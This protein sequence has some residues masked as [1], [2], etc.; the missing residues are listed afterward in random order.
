VFDF[1]VAIAL[2]LLNG[3]F[4]LSE[5]AIVS[6]RKAR[7]KILADQGRTGAKAALALADD[8]GRFLSTIQIGITLIGIVA[9]AYSGAAFGQRLADIFLDYGLPVSWAEFLGYGV[10]ISIITYLS[11]VIGELVPKNLALR[12]AEY[13]ACLVAPL[14][15]VVSRVGA[16]V[17]FVLDNSTKLIFKAFGKTSETANIITD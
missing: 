11:V 15:Q 5:L 14:M 4:S 8:P 1:A 13:L 7:L 17:V 12:N 10:V 16:P 3:V 2:I 9:G 6:V